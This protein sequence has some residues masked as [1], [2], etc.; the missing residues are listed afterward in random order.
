MQYD[1]LFKKPLEE[2]SDDELADLALELKKK[3]KYP[4]IQKSQDKKKD[5][6]A[7]LVNKFVSKVG[8]K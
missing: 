7:D 2:M 5:A 8:K 1:D 6:V 4:A 3:Q